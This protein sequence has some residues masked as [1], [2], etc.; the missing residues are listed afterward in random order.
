M[1]WSS[2]IFIQM[3]QPKQPSRTKET[4]MQKNIDFL[5][6]MTFNDVEI[7][8]WALETLDPNPDEI[9]K[10]I[11]MIK[12]RPGLEHCLRGDFLTR[13]IPPNGSTRLNWRIRIDDSK[14]AEIRNLRDCLYQSVVNRV[15][16]IISLEEYMKDDWPHPDKKLIDLS[17]VVAP[18][19]R[20]YQ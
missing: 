11:E 8:S 10:L 1:K 14:G 12:E 7:S 19:K 18:I 5:R 6:N 9:D 17:G 2:T 16:Y 4:L 20:K 15:F 13:S 3:V